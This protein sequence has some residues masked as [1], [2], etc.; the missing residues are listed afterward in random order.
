MFYCETCKIKNG[1][2]GLFKRVVIQCQ[3]CGDSTSCYQTPAQDLLPNV[4]V[5]GENTIMYSEE[6]EDE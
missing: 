1:W 3:V 5:A 6:D 2:P 4:K